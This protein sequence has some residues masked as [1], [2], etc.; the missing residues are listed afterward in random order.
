VTVTEEEWAGTLN[1][2]P[3]PAGPRFPICPTCKLAGADGRY[4]C[5]CKDRAAGP[6]P[7]M[8][9]GAT[10]TRT[11][12]GTP[13]GAGATPF[14]AGHGY[15]R[16]FPTQ[17]LPAR[18]RDYAHD[19]AIRKQVPVDLPALMMLGIVGSVAGPR[20]MVRRDLD[21]RQPTN[22]YVACALESSAGKSPVVTELRYGLLK[23][24]RALAGRHDEAVRAELTRLNAEVEDALAMSTAVTTAFD[25]RDG[26]K[27]KAKKLGQQIEKLIAEPPEPPRLV[28]DGDTSPEALAGVM[29]ANDGNGP[30]IDDE[31]TFLRNLGGQY[32]GK[33]GNL[34]L[35]LVGYDCRY[36]RPTRATRATQPIDRAVLSLVIAP[37]PSIIADM[38]HN[39]TMH[40][41]GF[42]NRFIISV[43]GDLIGQ[44]VGRA[45][46]WHGDAGAGQK[47]GAKHQLWWADL[48]HSIAEYPVI[49][50]TDEDDATTIDLTR[51][52]FK[53]H[54]DYADELEVRAGVDGDLR[55]VKSWAMKEAGR[56]LRVAACLHLAAD[57]ST[58]DEIEQPVM[59]DAIAIS[60]WAIEHFLG[61]GAVVGLSEGADRIKEYVGGHAT[62]LVPRS[63]LTSAVFRG[64]IGATQLTAYIEELTRT[65]D[66]SYTQVGEGPGRKPWVVRDLRRA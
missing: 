54:Y 24:Q 55:P 43:P 5:G 32:S 38:K 58:D 37:Q 35:V 34:G 53:V 15:A 1:P 16:R 49:G 6:D 28:L 11:A 7:S 40:D 64:H 45:A 36:Y 12:S 52:A 2:R 56:A 65:G 51:G 13:L 60:R 10:S 8:A 59:E 27:A 20:I 57:K 9:N 41:L 17:H 33:T 50:A 25:E 39:L 26:Y 62:G 48:L 61:A 19:L 31:G 30:I 29:A 23:A 21:W 44:R 4:T 3:V 18:M 22:L 42:I 46:T 47:P 66:F 63:A 14:K